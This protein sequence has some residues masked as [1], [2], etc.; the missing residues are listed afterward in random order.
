MQVQFLQETGRGSDQDMMKLLQQALKG[1][2]H[3]KDVRATCTMANMLLKE[4]ELEREISHGDESAGADS[5]VAPAPLSE[6]EKQALELL[7]DAMEVSP[8]VGMYVYVCIGVSELVCM[9]VCMNV[10]VC[11]CVKK[12]KQALELLRDAMEVSPGVYIYIYVCVCG[13]VS[14]PVCM[15]R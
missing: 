8:G 5:S 7:R 4:A 15:F 10:C 9:Y 2:T 13:E 14:K 3:N 6:K 1:S 11:A 12:E